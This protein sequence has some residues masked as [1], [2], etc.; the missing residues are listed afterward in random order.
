MYSTS[1][2]LGVAVVHA[3][4][5]TTLFVFAPSSR[6]SCDIWDKSIFMLADLYICLMF[7]S[8]G[9]FRRGNILDTTWLIAQVVVNI[10]VKM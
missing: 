4:A 8:K 3:A 5:A 9:N 1:S 10:T 7:I 2:Y 6:S